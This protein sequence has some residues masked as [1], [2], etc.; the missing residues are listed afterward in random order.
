[1]YIFLSNNI[2]GALCYMFSLYYWNLSKIL[3]LLITNNFRIC[4]NFF[5]SYIENV[6]KVITFAQKVSWPKNIFFCFQ[7]FSI[8]SPPYFCLSS[9]IGPAYT[10]PWYFVCFAVLI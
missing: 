1:M 9:N 4:R 2:L 5:H 10:G 6:P 7:K 3:R 8:K